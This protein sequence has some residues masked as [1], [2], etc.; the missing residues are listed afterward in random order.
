MTLFVGKWSS[1]FSRCGEDGHDVE[2]SRKTV[3]TVT[4]G[5]T[6]SR[7]QETRHGRQML[8]HSSVFFFCG[9]IL[10]YNLHFFIK[11]HTQDCGA[12]GGDWRT[13]GLWRVR[14]HINTT[15]GGGNF[16][17]QSCSCMVCTVCMC[18]VCMVC[19]RCVWCVH[20]VYGVCTVCVRCVY[21]VQR[22]STLEAGVENVFTSDEDPS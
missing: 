22:G 20:G 5:N 16:G 2:T 13:G 9:F 3:T 8:R 10:K 7:Q 18:T 21:G 12:H 19:A 15:G 6:S 1:R 17:Y 14:G 11:W 4:H